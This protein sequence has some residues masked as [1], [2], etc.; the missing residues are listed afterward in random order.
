[1]LTLYS[2]QLILKYSNY[3][4]LQLILVRILLVIL[5]TDILFIQNVNAIIKYEK[6][7]SE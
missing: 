4:D 6:I 5:F 2:K 7:I 1:M 3:K